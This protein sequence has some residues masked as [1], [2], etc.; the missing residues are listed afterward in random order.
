LYGATLAVGS[1]AT[2][3]V[4]AVAAPLLRRFSARTILMAATMAFVLG[5]LMTVLA[6]SME[7]VLLGCVVRGAAAPRRECSQGWE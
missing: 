7:W 3:A 4:L 6:P 2:I 1:L 5:V